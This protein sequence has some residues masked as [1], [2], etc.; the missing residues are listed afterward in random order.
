MKS[1]LHKAVDVLGTLSLLATLGFGSYYVSAGQSIDDQ[2][3]LVEEFWALGL[4][5][6]FMFSAILFAMVSAVLKIRG[7]KK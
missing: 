6:L 7:G 3:F 2:G 1:K 5:W 4:A